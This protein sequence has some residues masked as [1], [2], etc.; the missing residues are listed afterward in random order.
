MTNEALKEIDDQLASAS[1][2]A[3]RYAGLYRHLTGAEWDAKADE[4][5]MW[6]REKLIERVQA[7]ELA[8]QEAA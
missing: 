8:H 7:E 2:D 5:A 3:I 4:L 6:L 1:Y